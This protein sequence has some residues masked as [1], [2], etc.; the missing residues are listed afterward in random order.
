MGSF[1]G[2]YTGSLDQKGRLILP[3]RF[4]KQFSP[5]A[6]DT[7]VLFLKDAPCIFVYPADIFDTFEQ[8]LAE[9]RKESPEMER[10]S[11]I[12]YISLDQQ[13]LDKQGRFIISPRL[14]QKV[15]IKKDVIIF[16]HYNHMEIWDPEE[17]ERLEQ[18][19]SEEDGKLFAQLGM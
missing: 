16:G 15:G 8:Q 4:R 17:F 11:R 6:D 12:L 2:L 13:K 14:Q 18:R 1:R 10:V 3:A 7:V 5:A 19:A 9:K